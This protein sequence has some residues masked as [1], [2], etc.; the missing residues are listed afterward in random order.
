LTYSGK[1][2]RIST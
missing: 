1:T 2:V